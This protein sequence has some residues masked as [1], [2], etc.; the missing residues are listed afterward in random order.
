[1]NQYEFEQFLTSAPKSGGY[2]P[3]GRTYRNA[4]GIDEVVV[5]HKNYWIYVDWL[6]DHGIDI[7]EWITECDKHREDKTLSENFMEWLYWDECDRH[8]NGKL[9]PTYS[10]PLGYQE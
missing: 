2:E 3:V 8:R 4:F 5:L 10:P 1:M 9:T 7:Q 6:V